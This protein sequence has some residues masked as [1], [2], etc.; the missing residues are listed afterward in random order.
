LRNSAF[1]AVRANDP[2]YCLTR[3]DLRRVLAPADVMGA[4]CPSETFLVP[5][6]SEDDQFGE[7]RTRRLGLET[8]DR[9]IDARSECA[10]IDQAPIERPGTYPGRAHRRPAVRHRGPCAQHPLPEP[11]LKH[12]YCVSEV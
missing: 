7:Y 10:S 5:E 2:L 9:L 3:D 6:N 8:F 11:L 1:S 12:Q 4:D